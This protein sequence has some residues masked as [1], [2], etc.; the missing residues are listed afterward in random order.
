MADGP[1]LYP[2]PPYACM[3]SLLH[4]RAFDALVSAEEEDALFQVLARMPGGSAARAD[5]LLR[6]YKSEGTLSDAMASTRRRLGSDLSAA[7]QQLEREQTDLERRRIEG[8][9]GSVTL[10]PTVRAK[11]LER[12]RRL[13]DEGV[14]AGP[15]LGESSFGAGVEAAEAAREDALLAA[16]EGLEEGDR[17]GAIREELEFREFIE[18]GESE[19]GREVPRGLEDEAGS[20]KTGPRVR[21]D[22]ESESRAHPDPRPSSDS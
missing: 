8:M 9:L 2:L 15:G 17:V 3:A 6:T 10:R 11:L 14:A 16:V 5:T 22:P 1:L 19:V 18:E 12:L 13:E 4:C 20:E 7:L 21:S